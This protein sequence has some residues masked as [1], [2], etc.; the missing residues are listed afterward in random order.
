MG[1]SDDAGDVR[2][3]PPAPQ[4]TPTGSARAAPDPVRL[5]ERAWYLPGAVNTGLVE[6]EDGLIAVDTGLDRGAANRILRAADRLGRPLAAIVNTHAHADHHGGNAQLVRRTGVPVLAP[7]IEEAVIRE[8]AYEPIYLFGGAAPPTSLE[9]RF[10]RAEPSPVDRVFAPGERLVV[11]GAELEVV[12]LRGHSIA[13]VGI[14]VDDVLFCA[15]A[16][17]GLGPLAKHRIPYLVNAGA[18]RG[19]LERLRGG[20]YGWHVP[21]HGEALRDAGPTIDANLRVIER[22]E[23]W[24]GERLRAEPAG[25]EALL[26]EWAEAFGVRL[27]DPTGWVLARATLLGYLGALER[28][29][30]ARVT[31]DAGRWLWSG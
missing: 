23:G 22:T 8:P 20:E 17:F 21:G 5:S 16:F 3:P 4:S 12:D 13:Q 14:A 27:A 11:A 24:I 1:R 7:R 31:I 28:R 10:L 15:D 19:S 18:A 29:G 9:N 30:D 2:P 6:G 26:A 25:T